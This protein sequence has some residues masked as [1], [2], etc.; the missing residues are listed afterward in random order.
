MTDNSYI[1]YSQTLSSINVRTKRDHGDLMS[2]IVE[3]RAALNQVHGMIEHIENKMEGIE[4]TSQA[5]LDAISSKS[6]AT[7]LSITS[8]RSLGEQIMAYVRTFPDDIRDLLQKIVLADWRT[9]QAVL[10]IQNRLAQSP[11]SSHDSNI[12]FTNALGEY[13]VRTFGSYPFCAR[14]AG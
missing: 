10:Q 6:D 2:K 3:N 5:K 1:M 14:S 9:Y 7:Q 11:T 4:A 13:R 8:L 12:Q